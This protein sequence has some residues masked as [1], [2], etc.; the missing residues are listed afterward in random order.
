M[1][2]D[3]IEHCFSFLKKKIFIRLL[4][5]MV[6]ASK[7]TECVYLIP[8]KKIL[9]PRTSQRYTLPTFPECP[10]KIILDHLSERPNLTSW[11]CPNLNF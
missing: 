1:I 9:V 4:T 2:K 11:R 8:S 6:N 5:S 7:H 10:L 3:N